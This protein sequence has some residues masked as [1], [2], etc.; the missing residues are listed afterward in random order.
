MQKMLKVTMY[1]PCEVENEIDAQR[2]I[3]QKHRRISREMQLM[4][5]RPV[6]VQVEWEG[7]KESA[8]NGKGH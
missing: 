5:G 1:I 4:Q 2:T 3:I 8:T 6:E 7:P